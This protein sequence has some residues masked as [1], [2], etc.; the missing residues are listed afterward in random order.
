LFF[1]SSCHI[2]DEQITNEFKINN[3]KP[4]PMKKILFLSLIIS[5]IILSCANQESKF[6]QGAWKNVLFQVTSVDSLGNK[7]IKNYNIDVVKMWSE[8]NFSFVGQWKQDTIIK[9][10]Y[11]AGTYKLEGNRYEENVLY[12]F[13]KPGSVMNYNLKA[14][15]E[16]KND[17]LIQTSPVDS[18]GQINKSKYSVE[19]YVQLK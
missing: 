4:I 2:F 5:L 15:L 17:T 16:L 14:L 9:D 8:K 6:P 18:N 10:F 11:G 1:D 12:H 7:V 3:L 13:S 19:K